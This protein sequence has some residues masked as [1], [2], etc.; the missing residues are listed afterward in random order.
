MLFATI[1]LVFFPPVVT[2]QPNL[3]VSPVISSFKSKEISLNSSRTRR[4]KDS[5]GRINGRS[6]SSDESSPQHQ[7][8]WNNMTNSMA[9]DKSAERCTQKERL[10]EKEVDKI[11]T[12]DKFKNASSSSVSKKR[13]GSFVLD[14]NSIMSSIMVTSGSEEEREVETKKHVVGRRVKG[15]VEVTKSNSRKNGSTSPVHPLKLDTSPSLRN[16]VEKIAESKESTPETSPKKSPQRDRKDSQNRDLHYSLGIGTLPECSPR[17]SVKIPDFKNEHNRDI[18]PKAGK[19][20]ERKKE[21]KSDVLD[22]STD[23][24]GLKKKPGAVRRRDTSHGKEEEEDVAKTRSRANALIRGQ[25]GLRVVIDE[26]KKLQPP[27]PDQ[28]DSAAHPDSC[29]FRPRGASSKDE[30]KFK[31]SSGSFHRQMSG[32]KALGMF[33]HKRRSQLADHDPTDDNSHGLEHSG[34]HSLTQSQGTSRTSSSSRLVDSEMQG[35][36]VATV[37]TKYVCACLLLGS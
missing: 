8:W 19:G 34:S 31:R 11:L 22:T 28:F 26:P 21:D 16:K 5:V 2:K 18:A 15:V 35:K 14:V 25:E 10:K 32:D 12:E 7:R 37:T 33:Y 23:D 17:L 20:V 36:I 4:R 9:N 13:S 3:E 1:L 27:K 30:G 29:K 24:V 6:S